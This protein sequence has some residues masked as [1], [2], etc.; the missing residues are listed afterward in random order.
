[1]AFNRIMERVGVV[2]SVAWQLITKTSEIISAESLSILETEPAIKA[3]E[4]ATKHAPKR[5][6][7]ACMVE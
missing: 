3:V 5:K 6:N 2:G 4:L 1:M 7:P